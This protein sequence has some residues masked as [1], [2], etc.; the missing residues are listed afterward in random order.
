MNCFA[1]LIS[2]RQISWA[3]VW[4]GGVALHIAIHYPDLVRSFVFAGGTAY[5]PDGLHPE[6]LEGIKYMTPDALAGT[7]FQQIYARIA[8]HS[9]AWPTL[10]AKIQ[11]MD[12]SFKGWSPEKVQSIKAPALLIIGDS[13]IVRPEHT[14]Q[15]FRLLGGGDVA[16]LPRS[17]LAVLSGTTHMTLVNRAD[18]LLSMI[19]EFLDRPISSK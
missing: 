19:G 4:G 3:T 7:P 13:D 16:G 17:Q 1:S 12:L 18:W 15:M 8:P 9:G 5:R 2:R 14:V 10:I 6:V 11:Q